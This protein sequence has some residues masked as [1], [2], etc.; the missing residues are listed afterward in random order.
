MRRDNDKARV[1]WIPESLAMP[2]VYAKAQG[3]TITRNVHR[4]M[5]FLTE[6]DCAVWC[7]KNP[8]PVFKPVEH[9]FMTVTSQGT[10]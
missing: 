8:M 7:E 10:V 4:A 9:L 2:G 6:L 3:G 5:Q 1:V